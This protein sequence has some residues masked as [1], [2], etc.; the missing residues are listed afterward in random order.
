MTTAKRW[1]S[2]TQRWLCVAFLLNTVGILQASILP[3]LVL[4]GSFFSLPSGIAIDPTS[5][6]L[7]V[8]DFNNNMV[9]RFN[10][11]HT[12][13]S[14]SSPSFVFGQPNLSSIIAN[15]PSGALS[16]AGLYQPE[17]LWVDDA[18]SLWVADSGNW[19]VLWFANAST[20]TTF[21]PP[22]TGVVGQPNFT[23]INSNSVTAN[24][25]RMVVSARTL[26]STL[27]IADEENNR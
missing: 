25:L 5:N 3:D 6:A 19:R 17:G 23:S 15:Y 14:N 1:A 20:L 22:A 7:Y 12:L 26:G 21:D 9:M 8:A 18:G 16:A 10:N 13:V 4:Q 11:R 24:R 27:W 2:T